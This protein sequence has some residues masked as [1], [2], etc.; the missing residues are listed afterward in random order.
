VHIAR[1]AVF[2]EDKA[3]TWDEEDVS[4]GEPF[5]MEYV[6]AGSTSQGIDDT[7]LGAP[8]VVLSPGQHDN[9]AHTPLAAP[10]NGGDDQ[11]SPL[12]GSPNLDAEAGDALLKFR[13]L[14]SGLREAPL[15]NSADVHLTEVLLASIDGEP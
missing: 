11:V 2:E 5:T 8:L 7:R 15:I 12:S 9:M 6:S 4:E 1:D 14:D 13:T 3:W 10:A